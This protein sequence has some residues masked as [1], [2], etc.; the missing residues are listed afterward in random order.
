MSSLTAQLKRRL[1]LIVCILIGLFIRLYGVN[2]PLVDYHGWRQSDTASI[3]VNFLTRDFNLFRP[4]VF[5]DGP[6]PNVVQLELQI[7]PFIIALIAKVIGYSDTLA[8]LIPIAFALGTLYFVFRLGERWFGLRGAVLSTL[9][10]S[11]LPLSVYFTRTVQPESF[12]LFC[13]VASV[14]FSLKWLDDGER[15]YRSRA[16][17]FIVLVPLAKLTAIFMFVPILFIVIRKYRTQWR[18]Y[19]PLVL[20]FA[21]AIVIS[22]GYY[23]YMQSVADSTFVSSIASKHVWPEFFSLFTNTQSRTF[24]SVTLLQ[25]I[26]IRKVGVLLFLV[27][28]IMVYRVKQ[29][30]LVLYAW[31]V[32]VAAYAATIGA[33]IKYDYYLTTTT[34][35]FALILGGGLTEMWNLLHKR[36]DKQEN[37]RQAMNW[38]GGACCTVVLL[39][40]GWSSLSVLRPWYQLDSWVPA[41]GSYIA[42]HTPADAV[43]INGDYNPM[44]LFYSRRPGYRIPQYFATPADIET[45]RTQGASYYLPTQDYGIFKQTQAYLDQYKAITTP[46]GYVFYQLTTSK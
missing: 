32:G 34:P 38:I 37:S 20:T 27:C 29:A 14:W 45:Y 3:A 6:F 43:M 12:A 24:L 33:I 28:A 22:A 17:L 36:G 18:R 1:W 8:R 26:L 46:E 42:A 2:H 4:Q 39:F 41:A 35:V 11:I 44:L 21:G 9:F 40:M 7:T 30:R 15:A 13:S 31:L 10:M 25:D 16:I 23:I 5:Y 19:L